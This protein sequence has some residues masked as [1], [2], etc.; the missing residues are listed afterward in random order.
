MKILALLLYVTGGIT[1]AFGVYALASLAGE[2]TR[3][4]SPFFGGQALAGASFVVA[5]LGQLALG[6]LVHLLKDIRDALD[7]GAAPVVVSRSV[8]APA[9]KAPPPDAMPP[10][11][12]DLAAKST[13]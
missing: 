11:R 13:R 12:Y 7:N 5:G 6:A 2:A 9:A 10:P 1:A 4:L 3:P 8:A